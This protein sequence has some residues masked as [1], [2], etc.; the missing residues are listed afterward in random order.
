MLVLMRLCQTLVSCLTYFILSSDAD[1]GIFFIF[2][3]YIGNLWL[4]YMSDLQLYHYFSGFVSFQKHKPQLNCNFPSI[5]CSKSQT[6]RDSKLTKSTAA[7]QRDR[8]TDRGNTAVT[9]SSFHGNSEVKPGRLWLV[10]RPGRVVP[11][12]RVWRGSP[13]HWCHQRYWNQDQGSSL[14]SHTARERGR[15]GKRKMGRKK[16]KERQLKVKYKDQDNLSNSHRV[17]T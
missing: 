5:C 14:F 2:H 17:D 16:T 7:L 6:H 3:K 12:R 10:G 9:S 11:C 13:G 8:Q 4:K 15:G 1:N